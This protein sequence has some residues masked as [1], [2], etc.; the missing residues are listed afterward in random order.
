MDWESAKAS[1]GQDGRGEGRLVMGLV[2]VGLGVLFLLENLGLVYVRNVWEFW[3][4]I[5]MCWAWRV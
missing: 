3:P 4:I 1:R 2:V 5:L